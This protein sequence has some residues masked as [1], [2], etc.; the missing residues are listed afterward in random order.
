MVKKRRPARARRANAPPSAP[1]AFGTSDA[2]GTQPHETAPLPPQQQHMP[3]LWTPRKGLQNGTPKPF[4][5]A[6]YS[7]DGLKPSRLLD[8]AYFGDEAQHPSS[9]FD[10]RVQ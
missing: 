4:A 8:T 5:F 1:G 3:L 9:D 6:A 7:S 10:F 2:D